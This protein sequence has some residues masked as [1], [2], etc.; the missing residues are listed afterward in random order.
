MPFITQFKAIIF[1]YDKSIIKILKWR[2]KGRER[3]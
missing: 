1:L 3:Q 2:Q